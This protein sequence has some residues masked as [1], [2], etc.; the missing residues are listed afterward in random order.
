M[1]EEQQAHRHKMEHKAIDSEIRNSRL[2]IFS[3]FVICMTTIIC[4]AIVAYAGK[5]WP[6]Y[7]IIVTGLV[8]LA[9][10]FVY[11]TATRRK[12]RHQRVQAMQKM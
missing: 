6:G 12:E 5:E 4:G 10:V 9:G 2:G 8:S 1:A 11:G 3:G 7:A